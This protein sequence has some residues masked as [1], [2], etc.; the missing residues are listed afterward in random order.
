M[1]EEDCKAPIILHVTVEGGEVILSNTDTAL[2]KAVWEL[3]EVLTSPSNFDLAN[4][5]KNSLVNPSP[6]ARRDIIIATV[7]HVGGC[8]CT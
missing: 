5:V 8:S 3:Q 2:A 4:L 1:V 6:F 7:I